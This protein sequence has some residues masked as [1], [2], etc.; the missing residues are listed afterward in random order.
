[1]TSWIRR[2]L[3]LLIL[4]FGGLLLWRYRDMPWSSLMLLAIFFL[5]LFLFASVLGTRYVRPDYEWPSSFT[6]NAALL[7]SGTGL[8]LPLLTGTPWALFLLLAWWILLVAYLIHPAGSDF[9]SAKQYFRD[10]GT[11]T[12]GRSALVKRG[13]FIIAFWPVFIS[14]TVWFWGS[15]VCGGAWLLRDSLLSSV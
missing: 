15:L 10:L 6:D 3:Q 7:V 1:M 12:E 2:L 14:K 4:S 8:G 13:A 9:Q 5:G 11:Q